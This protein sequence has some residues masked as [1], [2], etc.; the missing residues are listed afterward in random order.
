M[1]TAPLWYE[2]AA[3]TD[4]REVQ[5]GGSIWIQAHL[6]TVLIGKGTTNC[7]GFTTNLYS[8]F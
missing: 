7:V 4:F 3:P 5:L 2:P 6:L 8:P 1:V